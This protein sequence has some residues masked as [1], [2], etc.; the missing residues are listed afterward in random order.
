MSIDEA[1]NV[2]RKMKT[3]PTQCH[4]NWLKENFNPILKQMD[5]K[6]VMNWGCGNCVKN[7]MNMLIGWQ[8]RKIITEQQKPKPK[9][10]RKRNNA[11]KRTK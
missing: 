6:I 3:L 1:I 8:D 10:K 4:L 11:K 2:F 9:T 7:Y 5:D